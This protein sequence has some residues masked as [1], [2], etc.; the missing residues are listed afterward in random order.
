MQLVTLLYSYMKEFKNVV[1][2][3][4]VIRYDTSV[5]VS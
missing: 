3:V 1:A 4:T 2:A 5:Y